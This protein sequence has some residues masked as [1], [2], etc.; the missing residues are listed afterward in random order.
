MNSHE[1]K[2]HR[3]RQDDFHL[4]ND[5]NSLSSANS[6]VANAIMCC[7]HVTL[8]AKKPLRL[9]LVKVIKVAYGKVSML[10]T[11]RI[12]KISFNRQAGVC[13]T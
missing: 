4:K 11:G 1:R 7:L 3:V 2:I 8:D 13:S 5:L 6:N 10:L 9:I 12:L